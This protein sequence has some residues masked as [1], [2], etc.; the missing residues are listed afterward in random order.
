MRPRL[1]HSPPRAHLR[2]APERVCPASVPGAVK[3]L[4]SGAEG[5]PGRQGWGVRGM[6]IS[7]AEPG[8]GPG[9]RGPVVESQAAGP[10][11][12]CVC[13]RGRDSRGFA[14]EKYAHDVSF[15]VFFLS[16]PSFG[17]AH[18]I[19]LLRQRR[20]TCGVGRWPFACQ[21]QRE[22]VPCRAGV[23]R[24]TPG[25][26]G[27]PPRRRGECL[28]GSRP[29]RLGRVLSCGRHRQA[30]FQNFAMPAPQLGDSVFLKNSWF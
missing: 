12:G 30:A 4:N 16:L 29:L 26:S 7:A 13:V 11:W 14:F 22:A 23:Q 1:S 5:V 17:I 10:T 9:S 21:E 28:A 24:A 8:A 6:M 3:T 20:G 25:G 19:P 18:Q 2:A 15:A 27:R